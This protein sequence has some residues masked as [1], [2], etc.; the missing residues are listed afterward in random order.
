MFLD[1]GG[2]Y[3]ETK[4]SVGERII[5]PF[6]AHKGVTQID[7]LWLSHLDQDHSGALPQIKN[8]KINRIIANEQPEILHGAHFDY[9]QQGQRW[10][11]NPDI[12]IEVLWPPKGMLKQAAFDKNE[13]SCVVLMTLK[14]TAQSYQFL[15]MGDVG[16][17]TEYQLIQHYPNLVVDVL[18]L[19][20][21]GSKHSSAYDF[22]KHVQP[23]IA[24]VSAGLNNRYGHP[25]AAT[26]A[27]LK[28]LD[29]PL[30]QTSETG[31][32]Q[33]ILDNQDKLKLIPYRSSRMWLMRD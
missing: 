25:S 23:K 19:G 16:W 11:W 30:H 26:L 28:S 32:I 17:E 33:F 7:E 27:R 20:H 22:L 13:T 14:T 10:N 29:I 12:Q 8:I 6:L 21:H 1:V 24:I 4:F 9:C 3:D 15:M 2:Y 5:L 18:V 31:N